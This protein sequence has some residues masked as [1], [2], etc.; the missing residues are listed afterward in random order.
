MT[1]WNKGKKTGMAYWTGK[2]MSEETKK[3][4]SETQKKI[5]EIRRKNGISFPLK[6]KKLSFEHRLAISRG[7]ERSGWK[8]SGYDFGR[9]R[10]T[11]K[12]WRKAIMERDKFICQICLIDYGRIIAHHIIPTKANKNLAFEVSN[13]IALCQK[14]H[15]DLHNFSLLTKKA[16]NSGKLNLLTDL[17]RALDNPEPS[18]DGHSYLGRC[19]DYKVSPNNNPCTSLAPVNFTG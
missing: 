1:S 9:T 13:G 6:G 11:W 15:A 14:C 16:M 2:K 8:K 4:M 10:M 18:Q 3:K 19:N 7:L 17:L 5:H 12:D